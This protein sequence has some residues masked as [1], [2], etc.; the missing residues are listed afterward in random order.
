MSLTERPRRSRRNQDRPLPPRK[1]HI[2]EKCGCQ[3][4]PTPKKPIKD[5]DRYVTLECLNC[6][7][8]I[9]T[10]K[11]LLLGDTHGEWSSLLHM[12]DRISLR[13]ATILHVG[14]VGVGFRQNPD[15]EIKSLN[16]IDS[17]LRNRGIVI[18]AIRGNHD[19][20]IYFNGDHLY[21]NLK[22]LPDYSTLNIN[23]ERFLFV[24]GAVSID[25]QQRVPDRSWWSGEEL[26]LDESRIVECDILITHTAPSWVG[27]QDKNGIMWF[28]NRDP[29]LWDELRHERSLMDKLLLKC[30]AKQHYCGHFHL[31]ASMKKDGVISR[32]LDIAEL[33]EYKKI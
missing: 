3:W 11:L 28:L 26:I 1:I 8:N 30:G 5:G 29:T 12:F 13:D 16:V 25:R 27:P 24:G 4:L 23:D 14:D 15:V 18:Y 33:H 7:M 32:I 22:L 21:D 17:E 19:D 31:R 6:L 20:P 9:K 10:E 2:C